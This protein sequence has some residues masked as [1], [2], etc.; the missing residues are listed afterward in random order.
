LSFQPFGGL[1]DGVEP[2]AGYVSPPE[3]PGIGFEAKARLFDLFT[4]LRSSS[5]RR[6]LA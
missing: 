3:T 2:H 1:A 6:R 4:S 5:T